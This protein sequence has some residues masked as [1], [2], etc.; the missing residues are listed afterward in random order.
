MQQCAPARHPYCVP[1]CP[2][3]R[4]SFSTSP[5]PSTP[6][7]SSPRWADVALRDSIAMGGHGRQQLA[8][9][10]VV[11]P[12]LAPPRIL[13]LRRSV[14]ELVDHLRYFGLLSGPSPRAYL[15]IAFR[16]APSDV[17]SF[18]AADLAVTWVN[19][20]GHSNDGHHPGLLPVRKTPVLFS[21]VSAAL[22]VACRACVLSLSADGLMESEAATEAPFGLVM[23]G[24]DPVSRSDGFAA[25]VATVAIRAICSR[26]PL[27]TPKSASA[28]ADAAAMARALVAAQAPLPAT[29]VLPG[30]AMIFP[31]TAK[32]SG[33]SRE[34]LTTN[35]P[36]LW[37]AGRAAAGSLEAA[38]AGPAT[39][40]SKRRRVRGRKARAPDGAAGG[41]AAD[42]DQSPAAAPTAGE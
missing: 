9:P 17:L 39:N 33:S 2:L 35:A 22:L 16:T 18:T 32:S 4:R 15:T 30:S 41:A 12:P 6:S 3:S 11:E 19:A 27:W 37:G 1:R 36:A 28:D 8:V 40:P 38:P 42:R 13:A 5:S 10:P 25:A 34:M 29:G 21:A 14:G 31:R 24:L 23:Y 26:V 20:G 7:V